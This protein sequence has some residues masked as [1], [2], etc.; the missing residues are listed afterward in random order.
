DWLHDWLHAPTVAA[1]DVIGANVGRFAETAPFGG[2]EA[3][4]A[5][6][7]FALATAIIVVTIAL[8]GR[9]AVPVAAAAG[10]PGGFRRILYRKWYVDEIYDRL[11]VRPVVFTSRVFWRV[12]DQGII[13]GLVNGA[14]Y[15]SRGMGWLGSRLQTGQLNTY[16]FAVVIGVL[17]LLGF[18]VL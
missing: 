4:W 13:D 16:A 7:S 5:M 12:V 3:L 8:L 15:F 1:D 11:I 14:G 18:A 6:V 9:K 2:G 17:L 10:E